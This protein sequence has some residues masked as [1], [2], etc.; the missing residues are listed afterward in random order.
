[1]DTTPTAPPPHAA[2]LIRVLLATLRLIEESPYVSP[3]SVALGILR[4]SVQAMIAELAAV[5]VHESE[6]SE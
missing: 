3:N 5:A 4:G 2:T 1:M 6:R